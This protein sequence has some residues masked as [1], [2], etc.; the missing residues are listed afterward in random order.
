LH[1]SDR[2][3]RDALRAGGIVRLRRGMYA[4]ADVYSGCDEAGKHLILA[5]SVVADQTGRVSLA[6][7]S[8]AALHGYAPYGHDY[9]TVHLIRLDRGAARREAGVNHHVVR[10]DI[11]EDLD[12][13]DGVL[14]I[15]PARTVWEV[16][17]RSDLEAGVVAADSALHRD[18]QLIVP[19][20]ALADRSAQFPGSRSVRIALLL[21]DPRAES[22]GESI[23]RVQFY[24]YGI[25]KPELQYRVMS[26]GGRLVGVA[27]FYW[28][29]HRH[30]GEFDGKAKYEQC[31]RPGES[32]AD[33]VFRE[34]HREGEMRADYRGMTR[35]IWSEVMPR[36]ARHTMAQ[37]QTR[38]DQSR[39]LYARMAS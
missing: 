4:P 3:L 38:L 35:F 36:T 32:P 17:C 19:I 10:Q 27:D 14:A 18:P 8:A 37:L 31:L 5:R 29:E 22:A 6:G 34:K 33:Y 23:T 24:R 2:A 25:P 9:S 30:L 28:E 16:A 15:N 21:A 20:R 11:E 39:T 26:Q 13:Y 7:T 1:E 12:L